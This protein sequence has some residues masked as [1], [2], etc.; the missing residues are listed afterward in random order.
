LRRCGPDTPLMT[1]DSASRWRDTTPASPVHCYCCP[2]NVART[3]AKLQGWAYSVSDASVWVHLLASSHLETELPAGEA[4]ALTQT[5]DYPWDGRVAIA[6]DKAPESP[7]DL[8]VRIPGWTTGATATVNGER[9]EVALEPGSYAAFHRHWS[10]GDVLE[11]R[12]SMDV[13]FMQAQPLVEQA[14]NQL[15]VV[16]GPI[17]YCLE[18]PDLPAGVSIDDVALLGGVMVLDGEAVVRQPR[19]WTD[20][21]YAPWQPGGERRMTVTLIPYYAWANRGESQM[22]V[23][24][25]LAG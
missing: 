24:L 3:I 2:P 21:L 5:T 13:T 7:F 15:A 12:L 1:N 4:V 6:V 20:R 22:T 9:V 25:P 18:S 10:P 23:W 17:V 11:L 14:R 8:R 19:D 16:R